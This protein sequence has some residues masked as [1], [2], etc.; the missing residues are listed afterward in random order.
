MV[1][2][3]AY[4]R[5]TFTTAGTFYIG[6]SNANNT[7]YNAVTGD[8]D[9][10][11]GLHST[12]SYQLIVQALPVDPDDS[13]TEA[14]SA[15]QRF[16]RRPI[17]VNATIIVPTST[18]TCIA[19]RSPPVKSSISTSTRRSTVPAAWARSC[20]CSTRRVRKWRSTTMRRRPA[21]RRSAST[22]T[23]DSRL[24]RPGR[25]TS[26]SRTRP[27]RC[28]TRRPAAATPRAGQ[29]S[30][31]DYQLIVQTAPV[32]PVDPD[33]T[34]V[35]ASC[36]SARFRRRPPASTAA[37]RPIW[38]WT[39]T[40]SRS[41]PARSS[42]STSTR[43]SMVRA[44]WARSCG[45]S[46]RR[47]RNWPSTTMRIAPGENVVGF[48]AY[49][50]FT[51]ATA[52][53]FYIGVSNANNTLYN[54]TTG[55]GDVAGG[56]NATGT[57]QLIVQALPV[58]TDDSL[59]RSDL[60]RRDFDDA[61]RRS[62]ARSFP[63]STWTCT[64][65]RSPP[66][67]SSISTSTRRSTVPAAWARSCGCS[68]RRV[69]NS[70][71]TTMP[72]RPA[73]TVVGFDAYLRFTFATAGTYYI[74][75]SNVTNTLYNPT[76][77]GGDTA[78][79]LF[80]IGDYQLIVQ[81]AALLRADPDDTLT[82]ATSLGAISTTPVVVN[83]S[84][85]PDT[86]VD[87]YRFTVT[88]GQVVDFDIDTTLNGPGGLGS[89]LRLFNSA[90]SGNCLQQRWHRA[91]RESCSD[92][93]PTCDSRLPPPARS[94][95][96]SRTSTTRCTTRTTGNGD[97]AGG[98]NATGSYQLIVQALPVDTDDSL[99]EATSLGAIS[100]TPIVVNA[101]IFARHRRGPV[102]LHGR[103]RP[104]RRF[105]YRHAAQRSR[106]SG[107]VPAAVQF[108]RV[109]NWPS[110]T[111]RRPPARPSSASTPTCGSRS[112]R[113]ARIYIGVSNA[114]NTL[115]NATPA[116]AIRRGACTRLATIS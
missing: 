66:A 33:D 77:G 16:R 3:D 40:A 86:D 83:D 38:T 42:I 30:I 69:R 90:G 28:T 11:G 44:A 4:L 34:L 60:A 112:P 63:I 10:A 88:A 43:R 99:T 67:R 70:P 20:G 81:T 53:T 23:C 80:S 17:V 25:T 50:R 24:P 41:P 64:A 61:R 74:G 21:K 106:R 96:A 108:R 29:F 93:T 79:G 14:T 85:T 72:R 47:V 71:S 45:C 103:R 2:F 19:S 6:V 102:P 13:L 49:L 101:T 111:M 7:L 26:A 84:I 87:L 76:T 15:R 82:E 75:V 46:I 9:V 78:G 5:C 59:T 65:L 116:T 92:S 89:F 12:G 115:Y 107:L 62:T 95:S 54:P 27:T 91:G 35:E 114:N 110:T 18:W 37:L 98:A 56:A 68:T 104:G 22:P 1:G 55:N 94:T 36:R 48:D 51:F 39:C 8:G 32:V 31:G 109:R 58:D 52:G 73:R 97:V 57:Y 113:Q 100:T 105:R